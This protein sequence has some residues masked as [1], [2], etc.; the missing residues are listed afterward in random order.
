MRVV[1]LA[2]FS[3]NENDDGKSRLEQAKTPL[4]TPD[5]RHP[6]SVPKIVKHMQ[7]AL[8]RI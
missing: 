8:G 7:I 2:Y 3:Q 5:P 1:L 4:C 6:K